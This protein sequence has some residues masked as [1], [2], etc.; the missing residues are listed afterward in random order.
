MSKPSPPSDDEIS[1]TPFASAAGAM[2]H[3]LSQ[4]L[5][6]LISETLVQQVEQDSVDET[7][8]EARDPAAPFDSTMAERAKRSFERAVIK[9]STD[10]QQWQTCPAALLRGRV[11]HYNKFHEKWR[12]V[13][14]DAELCPRPPAIPARKRQKLSLW[15]QA[16]KQDEQASISLE[17][18]LQILAYNDS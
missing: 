17:G 9:S 2:G 10:E 14:E 1:S 5:D 7:N 13:V 16:S 15:Q 11:D 6:D 18:S 8:N 12:I 3:C 4:A